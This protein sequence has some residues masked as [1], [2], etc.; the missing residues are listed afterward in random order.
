MEIQHLDRLTKKYTEFPSFDE[1]V[2]SNMIPTISPKIWEDK[3]DAERLADAFDKAKKQQKSPIRAFRD[4]DMKKFRKGAKLL[5][6][7]IA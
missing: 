6:S 1:L 4:K 2:T 5:L 3:A 7:L